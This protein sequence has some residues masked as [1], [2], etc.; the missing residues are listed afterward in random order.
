MMFK[1]KYAITFQESQ[2]TKRWSVPRVRQLFP[3][4]F[5]DAKISED[6]YQYIFLTH[7][8]YSLR[9]MELLTQQNIDLELLRFLF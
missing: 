1:S 5:T 3:Y 2:Q 8:S 7:R 6:P 9:D 4:Y